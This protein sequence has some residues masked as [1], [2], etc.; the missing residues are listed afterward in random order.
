MCNVRVVC[1]FCEVSFESVKLSNNDCGTKQDSSAFNFC[2]LVPYE[3]YLSVMY[4]LCACLEF[5]FIIL[6]KAYLS[7]ILYQQNISFFDQ[8]EEEKTYPFRNI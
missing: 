6:G 2:E 5:R 8:R 1:V 7:V 3:A 4:V